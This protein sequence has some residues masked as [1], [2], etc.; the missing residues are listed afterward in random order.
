ME[1]KEK[2]EGKILIKKKKSSSAKYFRVLTA[3]LQQRTRDALGPLLPGLGHGGTPQPVRGALLTG[4]G[5][6]P[7]DSGSSLCPGH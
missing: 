3:A 4:G 6:P 1:K 2:E 5:G 7:A